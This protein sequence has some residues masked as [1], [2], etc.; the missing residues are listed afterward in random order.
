MSQWRAKALELFPGMRSEVE[1]AESVGYLWIELI[2]HFHGYYRTELSFVPKES[3]TLTRPICLFATWCTRSESV[4]TQQAAWIEFYGHLPG[5]AMRC[6]DPVYKRIIRDLV[7]NIGIAEVEKMGA[8]LK[9]E[10]LKGFLA[11]ARQAD[12]ERRRRSGKR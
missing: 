2:S 4:D 8:F 6:A 5:F 9:P 1:S 3:A 12:D 11:D 7:A 10:D